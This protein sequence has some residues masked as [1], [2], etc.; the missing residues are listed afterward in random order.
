M[1]FVYQ[2]NKKL[3]NDNKIIYRFKHILLKNKI[4]IELSIYKMAK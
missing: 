1:L 4:Q 3:K 2:I